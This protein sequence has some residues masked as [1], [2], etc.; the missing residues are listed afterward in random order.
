MTLDDLPA[1]RQTQSGPVRL[2]RYERLEYIG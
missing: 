2:R 1:N